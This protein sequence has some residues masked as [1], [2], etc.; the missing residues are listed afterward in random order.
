MGWN[1][2]E[3]PVQ[4]NNAPEVS[5]Y[6][7]DHNHLLLKQGILYRRA[8]PRESEE[9]LLQMV[10]PAAQREVALRGCHDEVSHLGL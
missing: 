1:V 3:G 2:R 6:R 8:R 4:S 10:L 9:T 7:W 5:Q